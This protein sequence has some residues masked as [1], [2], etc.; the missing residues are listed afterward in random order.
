MD[1]Y[2]DLRCSLPRRVAASASPVAVAMSEM[3]N[4]T[5]LSQ[6]QEQK[7]ALEAPPLGA[8]SSAA[9]AAATTGTAGDEAEGGST[10]GAPTTPSQD[11]PASSSPP[12]PASAISAPAPRR[13]VRYP[14]HII[15]AQKEGACEV[16]FRAATPPGQ[17]TQTLQ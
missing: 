15:R 6:Y 7:E 4:E 14:Y 17:C 3:F 1:R 8:S 11:L 2:S 5:E 9:S 13:L 12:P 16:Q 10:V